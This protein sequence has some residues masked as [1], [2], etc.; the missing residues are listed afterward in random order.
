MALDNQHKVFT[1]TC[2]IKPVD[3][4]QEQQSP[5]HIYCSFGESRL[6]SRID[7][8]LLAP[9]LSHPNNSLKVLN[10]MGAS[11]HSP[12]IAAISTGNMHLTKPKPLLPPPPREAML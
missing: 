6:R 10:H 11:D 9:G 5:I 3:I 7:D 12:I 8:V 1:E 4:P 2:K